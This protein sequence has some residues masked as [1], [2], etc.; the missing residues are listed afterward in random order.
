MRPCCAE[1]RVCPRILLTRRTTKE[2]KNGLLGRCLF[3]ESPEFVPFGEQVDEPIPANIVESADYGGWG[4][5]GDASRDSPHE[6]HALH[7]PV[8]CRG[9]QV[10]PSQEARS[11]DALGTWRK[12]G[13]FYPS[14][15]LGN[16]CSHLPEDH[17]DPPHGRHDR[18]RDVISPKGR[19][20]AQFCSI[21]HI[22]L[23]VWFRFRFG[24][25]SISLRAEPNQ[26]FGLGL[27]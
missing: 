15:E 9:R 23:S 25:A 12:F 27:L 17:L 14:Q 5:L 11:R 7:V 2:P 22:Q 4:H 19:L 3:F 1:Q 13:P 18:R 6:A 21:T 26:P 24:F 8:L 20:F 16:R 10:R